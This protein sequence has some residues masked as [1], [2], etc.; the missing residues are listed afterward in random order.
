VKSGGMKIASGHSRR[1]CDA[2]LAEPMPNFR[3]S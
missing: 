1:A 2:G 3:A